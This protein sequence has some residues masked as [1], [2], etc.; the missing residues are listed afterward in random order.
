MTSS[1]PYK[2]SDPAEM[3]V[4]YALDVLE[5]DERSQFEQA[6][7][8]SVELD[9]AVREFEET[10]ADLAYGAPSVPMAANLKERLFQRIAVEPV[11][12]SSNLVTL[13]ELS[14]DELKQKASELDWAL[15][16]GNSGAEIA[17]WQTDVSFR[18]VAFF[19][20]KAEGGLF[21][22][23][24]H[25]SGETV[26]VLE[27]DFVVGQQVHRTGERISSPGDTSHQPA[28]LTGCL[29]FCVSSMD[30]DILPV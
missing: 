5:A 19:V 18:E 25:A 1:E 12:P 27:G 9:Q 2:D 3:A 11:G 10:A 14:I 7:L 4:L 28:T 17:T 16:P 15:M 23:H 24:A 6:L 21:P 13:L 20:R 30:D 8:D 22:N 26:L 29:L